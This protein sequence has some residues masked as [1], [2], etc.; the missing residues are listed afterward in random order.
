M[1][2][3]HFSYEKMLIEVLYIIA[4]IE[5]KTFGLIPSNNLKLTILYGICKTLANNI[6]F[7][8]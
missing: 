5:V 8:K 6:S 1:G 2:I 4:N 7:Y 3:V